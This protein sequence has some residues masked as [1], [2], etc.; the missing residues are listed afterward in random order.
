MG[1]WAPGHLGTGGGLGAWESGCMGPWSSS[2]LS[3][4][5]VYSF[6]GALRYVIALH[7]L[8]AQLFSATSFGTTTTDSA[9]TAKHNHQQV[10]DGCADGDQ[11]LA[12]AAE[13]SNTAALI[14][15]VSHDCMQ[16]DRS[17]TSREILCNDK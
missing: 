6:H 5:F 16:Q 17:G 13:E 8:L 9:G 12:R 7:L 1:T 11:T 10:A 4:L 2:I 14:L 3:L 15:Q